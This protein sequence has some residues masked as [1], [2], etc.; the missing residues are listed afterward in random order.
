MR[1]LGYIVSDRR[2]NNMKDFVGFANDISLVDSTKP[3]LVVGLKKAKEILGDKFNIL[4]KKIN[5]NVYW[6]FKKTE[7]RN[8]FDNDLSLFYKRCINRVT[9][10]VKYCYVNI[11]RL[12]YSKLKKLHS[13]LFS[14]DKKYIY[15]SNDMLYVLYGTCILGLSLSLLKY[16]GINP[17]KIL[18]KIKE[19]KNNEIYEQDKPF[20]TRIKRA[21]LNKDYVIPYFMSME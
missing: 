15:I 10:S 1:E 12:K 5:D 16:C 17:I 8:D 7:K 14:G 21:V 20:V 6:T 3:V 11:I 9:D 2:F 13:I 19:N 4:D 18:K